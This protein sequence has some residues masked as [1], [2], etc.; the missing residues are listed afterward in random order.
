[1]ICT[2]VMSYRDKFRCGHEFCTECIE[3]LIYY[4]REKATCPLCRLPIYD[5]IKK[6]KW[7]TA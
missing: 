5:N 7:I 6:W 3:E 2:E 1:M 4:N